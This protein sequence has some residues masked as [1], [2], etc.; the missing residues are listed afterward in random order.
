[1][2]PLK[3]YTKIVG[4]VGGGGGL[5]KILYY[6]LLTDFDL[7]MEHAGFHTA[8]PALPQSVWIRVKHAF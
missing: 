6:W 2:Q 7:Q 1:M 5:M 4:W 3:S 8:A